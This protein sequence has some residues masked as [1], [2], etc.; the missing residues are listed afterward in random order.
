[1]ELKGRK[2]DKEKPLFS[3]LPAALVE[4]LLS[5]ASG[6]GT[7]ILNRFNDLKSKREKQRKEL[8]ENGLIINESDLGYPPLPTTCGVDGSYAIERLLTVDFIA[9]A[10]VAVEGL[11]PPSEKRYWEQPTHSL[12][13]STETHHGDTATI[14]RA[15]MLGRELLL[16]TKAPHDIVMLDGT[17]TLP[18]IYFNQALNK[19]PKTQE[20]NCSREFLNYSLQYLEAYLSVLTNTRTDKHYVAIPKYSTRREIGIMMGWDTRQDDRSLLTIL[21][22]PGEITKPVPLEKPSQKWHINTKAIPNNGKHVSNIENEIEKALYQIYV[23]YYKP[24]SWLPA[25]RLEFSESVAK[26]SYRLSTIIHGLKHQCA[27]ASMMEPYPIYFADRTVKS[28]ARAFP[29][30]RQVATQHISEEYEGD[31]GEVFFAMH[32][33]RSEMGR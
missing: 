31:I 23:C 27:I 11:K 8:I 15:V 12:F 10:A 1:M 18:I 32:N 6:A 3:D 5:E 28:L 4:E 20:L 7:Q 30:F 21:L 9:A 29:A 14:L 13:V 33:Y 17:M 25:I 24:Q 26:N 16:A 2:M 22:Q 19:T